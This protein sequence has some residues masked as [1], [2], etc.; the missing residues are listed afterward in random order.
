MEE[1][2][3]ETQSESRKEEEAGRK[4]AEGGIAYNCKSGGSK[5]SHCEAR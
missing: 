2:V 5:S 1:E 4:R 3:E